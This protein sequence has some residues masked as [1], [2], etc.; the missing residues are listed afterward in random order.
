VKRL[1]LA[2]AV[3]TVAG[4]AMPSISVWAGPA[5]AA[6]ALFVAGF[7]DVRDVLDVRAGGSCDA[8]AGAYQF[9]G[10]HGIRPA[11]WTGGGLTVPACGPIPNDTGVDNF[12]APYPG[13]LWTPGYQCVEFSERYLYYRYGVTMNIP[14]DGDQIAAH[15]AAK[16]PGL[17]TIVPNGTPHRAP[18]D[19]DVLSMAEVPGFDGADGGHTAVVQASS[20]NAAGNGTVT[21]V[22]E[23]AA[24]SGVEVLPVDHWY[25]RYS[26][27]PYMEWL[28]TI[29]VVV[30]SPWLPTAEETRPYA[31]ALTATGGTGPY[32]WALTEG[33]LP[34]GL[35]LTSA[36]VL[37][38][39]PD[40]DGPGGG[41]D[42]GAWP[43]TLSVTDARGA[44]GVT[45]LSLVLTEPP[46]EY[47][48]LLVTAG[49]SCAAAAFL[50][51]RAHTHGA[52][53]RG[54]TPRC[55]T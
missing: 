29:G 10:S 26:G 7:R 22:E 3:L 34:E 2:F 8:L 20:V 39:T 1:A 42:A 38:G 44:I 46:E 17:F 12:I 6:P 21:I 24:P 40:A 36:G 51:P 35:A 13:A 25:V 50:Y 54:P 23:N 49:A 14:T 5:L 27:F 43:V 53:A 19:G 18:V 16:Y 4:F 15:Y 32:R 52:Y 31:I 41:D 48:C 55:R 37:A 9:P 47:Y 11:A 33:T 30:T 45:E 28:T